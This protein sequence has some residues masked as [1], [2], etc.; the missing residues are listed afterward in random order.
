MI[1]PAVLIFFHFLTAIIKFKTKTFLINKK[2]LPHNAFSLFINFINVN[3][4]LNM[5]K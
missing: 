5:E 3:E 2:G 1:H 4:Q